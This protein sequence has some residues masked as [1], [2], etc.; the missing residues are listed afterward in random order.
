MKARA[1]MV[2]D[3]LPGAHR[4]MNRKSGVCMRN[5]HRI[6]SVFTYHRPRL[7]PKVKTYV[8]DVFISFLNFVFKSQD[9]VSQQVK[10]VSYTIFFY[11]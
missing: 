7:S 6:Q 11:N 3:K 5:M 2:K 1:T 10:L 9:I 4:A 8:T